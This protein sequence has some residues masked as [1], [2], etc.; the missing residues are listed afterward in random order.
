MGTWV[1]CVGYTDSCTLFTDN[2]CLFFA[3]CWIFVWNPEPNSCTFQGFRQWNCFFKIPFPSWHNNVE[4]II[5][6]LKKEMEL[7]KNDFTVWTTEMCK[8]FVLGPK[9]KFI[10]LL[11]F[12]RISHEMYTEICVQCTRFCVPYRENSFAHTVNDSL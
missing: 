1:F 7:Q 9:W 8:N 3:K 4:N 10:I 5:N 2:F 11:K 12:A 6:Y